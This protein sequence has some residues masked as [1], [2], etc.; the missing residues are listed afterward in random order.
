METGLRLLMSDGTL[1]VLFHPKLSA[2]QYD[3]LLQV[4]QAPRTKAELRKA[5]EAV[6]GKWGVQ[7]D[8]DE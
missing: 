3:E 7:M 8:I 1:H 6:A 5:L 4:V 2:E